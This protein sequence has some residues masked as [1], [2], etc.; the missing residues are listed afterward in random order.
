MN[1]KVAIIGGGIGGLATACLLAKKGFKVQLFEKNDKVGGVANQFEA[2]GFTFD[3][4]PSWYLMPDVFQNYFDLLDEKVEDHLDLVRLDP[5]YRIYFKDQNRHFD[6][7]S[8]FERDKAIFEELEPGSS[9]RLREYLDKS[10]YQYEIALSGFMYKNYDTIFDFLN[11][12]TATEGREL[13]VFSPMH[14]YVQK[15]FSSDEVQ[16]IMEYQL[17]FLGSSPYNTPALYNIMSHIDFNMGVWYPRGGIHEIPKAL[18]KIGEKLGVE[19]FTNAPIERILTKAGR[20]AKGVR[21]CDGRE[22]LCDIVVA[23][24]SIEHVERNLLSAPHR[25]HSDRYWD[26]K[27][28]APSAFILYLGLN[29]KI[30]DIQ[31]HNLIFSEDWKT[32]FGEIFDDAKWPTDPSF[33][34]CAPSVTDESVAPEGKENL[35]VLV[36][37]APGLE[38]TPEFLEDYKQKTL[39]IME[40]EMK[41][42][43]LRDKIE[44]SK[45]FWTPD[46]ASRYNTTNGTALGLAHTM[47][48]T[49][50]L[51][52]N[53]KSKKLKNLFY[54]GANTNPGIGMPIQLISAELA[55][56][57]V[58]GDKSAS[59]LK[60]L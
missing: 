40:R 13:E 5:S 28:L 39:D 50:L 22:F 9:T 29:E 16:K 7:A 53:N 35:F 44:Y 26:K 38:A 55:Y 6:F 48:Q 57:R 41:I 54:V 37:I 8:D 36:P 52:P 20:R 15:F 42:P 12:Q 11:K 56:K 60:S 32:N 3:M 46:F 31:H 58:I 1:E 34:V 24:A 43:N 19:Y 10:K 4:G 17:V 21:L 47:T 49:A 23:N 45:T 2:Q 51:R 25:S 27:T 33:Y 30:P 59:H 18:R 14:K